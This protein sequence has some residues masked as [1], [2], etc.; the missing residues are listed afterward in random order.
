MRFKNLTDF[1]KFL[2][3]DRFAIL[4]GLILMRKIMGSSCLLGKI[5][6]SVNVKIILDL[7]GAGYLFGKDVFDK[8]LFANNIMTFVRAH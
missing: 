3:K 7:R 5:L 4:C 8:F 1:K 6:S 2:T